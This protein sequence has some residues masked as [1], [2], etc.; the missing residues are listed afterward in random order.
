MTSSL[1]KFLGLFSVFWPILILLL[2]RWSLLVLRFPSLAVP[3]TILWGLSQMYQPQLVSPSTPC[4]IFFFSSLASSRY[5]SLFAFYFHFVVCREGKVYYSAGSL[6]CCGLSQGLVEIKYSICMSNS[7]R[8]LY[9]SFNRADSGLCMYHFFWKL[10]LFL[11]LCVLIMTLN[12]IRW[13]DSSSGALCCLECYFLAITLRSTLTK[14][15]N[16]F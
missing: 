2:S 8:S 14:S 11:F 10:Y 4:S 13:W 15:S 7:H 9:V 6:F 16:T 5:L 1:L 3:L 12:C